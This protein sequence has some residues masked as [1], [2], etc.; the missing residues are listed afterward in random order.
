MAE[1]TSQAL[2]GYGCVCGFTCDDINK[3]RTH[4]IQSGR[5]EKGVHKSI[6]RI[7]LLT[8]DVVLPPWTE[9]SKDER[10]SSSF[11]LKNEKSR[12]QVTIGGGVTRVVTDN[13]G[14]ATDLRFVPRVYTTTLTP[15]MQTAPIAA[16]R[17][18]GWRADM[19][20]INF[21]DTVIY[22][23]FKEHGITLAAY[24]VDKRKDYGDGVI[25]SDDRDD[26]SGGGAIY[27]TPEVAPI[28]QTM[29]SIE[30]DKQMKENIQLDKQ[31]KEEEKNAKDTP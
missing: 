29:S 16:Q 28:T 7:N 22:N 2:E 27:G 24:I 15:I 21:L 26:E 10:A 14:E 8:K 20:F 13:V 6:G 4:L 1:D 19:P 30:M 11:S 17:Q 23:Y 18:W 12:A 31:I 5:K 25:A 3:L 9:R